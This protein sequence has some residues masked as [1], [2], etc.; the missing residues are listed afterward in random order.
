VPSPLSKIIE[1][2]RTEI[3]AATGENI[4]TLGSRQP[5]PLSRVSPYFIKAVVATED[6]RFWD[7]HGINKL[8]TVKALFI[9]LFYRFFKN[10]KKI[11]YR[12]TKKYKEK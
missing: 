9:T 4:M 3:F 1:T 11:I 10:L 12:K 7:H 2:P 5:V 8:R 6:H